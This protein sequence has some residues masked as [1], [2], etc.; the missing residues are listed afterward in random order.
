MAYG[1]FGDIDLK[2]LLAM[3]G[4]GRGAP[5]VD[6]SDPA[7]AF[8]AKRL[9]GSDMSAPSASGSP[10]PVA[11][12]MPDKPLPNNTPGPQVSYPGGY[13]NFWS[14]DGRTFNIPAGAA[15]ADRAERPPMQE[16]P[17][18]S[19]N[20]GGAAGSALETLFGKSS[21]SGTPIPSWFPAKAQG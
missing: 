21:G 20:K 17:K 14:Y 1:A 8:V 5:T 16:T 7:Q 11:Y 15:L 4:R 9:P 13:Q 18:T 19:V 12:P 10:P 2:A 6:M 3:A